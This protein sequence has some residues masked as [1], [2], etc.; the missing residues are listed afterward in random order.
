M[1]EEKG[2]P[3]RLVAGVFMNPNTE[4]ME[5]HPGAEG[6]NPIDVF[7][8]VVERHEA[9]MAQQQAPV[10]QTAPADFLRSGG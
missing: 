1:T 7:K 4:Q 8:D 6:I 3:L 9:A 5:I 10:I 2:E